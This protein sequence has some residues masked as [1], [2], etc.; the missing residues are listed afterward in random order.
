MNI[1]LDTF[2]EIGFEIG[3]VHDSI[4]DR[5]TAV[6]GELQCSLFAFAGSHGGVRFGT[7]FTFDLDQMLFLKALEFI[8]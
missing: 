2:V 1:Y 5:V 8:D 4:F 3:T 6:N 7:H